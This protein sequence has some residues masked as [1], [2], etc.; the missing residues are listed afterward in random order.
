MGLIKPLLLWG[1]I[2]GVTGD[3]FNLSN[4]GVQ[5][6]QKLSRFGSQTYLGLSISFDGFDVLLVSNLKNLTR[7]VLGDHFE[8]WPKTILDHPGP[9]WMMWFQW[10]S[11]TEG[12]EL[13][14]PGWFAGEWACF[15]ELPLGGEFR[16]RPEFPITG[17]TICNTWYYVVQ[18]Y[19]ILVISGW[20][21]NNVLW[22]VN[23]D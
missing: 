14:L 13:V 3:L 15:G 1:L 23:M 8:R 4:L 12:D 9:S 17:I 5:S 11:S 22:G 2:W 18:L 10:L 7:M 19:M 16:L 20:V 21:N 6:T